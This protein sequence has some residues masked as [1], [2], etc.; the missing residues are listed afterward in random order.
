MVKQI[1][2]EL[3]K[4]G[5]PALWEEGGGT[6]HTGNAIIVA[7][8][9]GEPLIPIYVRTGGPLACGRHALFMVRKGY[10]VISCSRWRE[11][12]NIEV[13]R[14]AEI[15][16]ENKRAT[17]ELLCEFSQGEWD[18]EPHDKLSAAINA[19][20]KKSK[21]YHCRQAHYIVDP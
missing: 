19:A 16:V 11:D 1:A 8:P 9:Q 15:N 2:I 13:W 4:R 12:Y 21:C 5:F 17:L 3:T 10:H 6:S 18:K 20:I 7:G 14:I